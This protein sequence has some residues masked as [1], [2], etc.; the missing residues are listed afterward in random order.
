MAGLSEG[1]GAAGDRIGDGGR[2]LISLVS[3]LLVC[4]EWSWDLLVG[5]VCDWRLGD[6]RAVGGLPGVDPR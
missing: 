6:E 4:R 5:E 2:L 1:R 3:R